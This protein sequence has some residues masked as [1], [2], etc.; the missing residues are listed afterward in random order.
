M[1]LLWYHMPHTTL[2]IFYITLV[3]WN[4]VDVHMKNTLP[5]SLSNVDAYVIAIGLEFFIQ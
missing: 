1:R 5:G 3:A 4:D 2:R